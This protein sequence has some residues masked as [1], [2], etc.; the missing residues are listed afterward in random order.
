[1]FIAAGLMAAAVPYSGKWK[2][3][4]ARSDFG[5]TTIAYEQMAGCEMKLTADGLSCTFKTDG[6]EEEG[7]Q[8]K[9][10]F[11]FMRAGVSKSLTNS[12]S[13]FGNGLGDPE[14]KRLITSSN[15]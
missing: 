5:E 12:A 8:A 9:H 1:M 10:C 6:K 14:H 2:L 4:P 3:N 11:L 7:A 13:T 15:S